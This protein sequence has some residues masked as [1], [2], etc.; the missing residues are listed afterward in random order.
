MIGMRRLG[1]AAGVLGLVAGLMGATS[2]A[3]GDIIYLSD[4]SWIKGKIVKETSDEYEV[5][6]KTSSGISYQGKLAKSRVRSITKGDDAPDAAK[7]GDAA[8]PAKDGKPADAPKAKEPAGDFLVVPLKGTFG[9][10]ITP[11]GVDTAL[12]WAV[13]KGVKHVVFTIDSPGGQVWAA[14]SIRAIIKDHAGKVTCHVVI[15]NAMSASIWVVFA[16]DKIGALPGA[17]LGAAVAFKRNDSGNAE[18]DEKFN[19]AIAAKIATE[20]DRLG[21]PGELARSMILTDQKLYAVQEGDA[22]KFVHD[23]P[24]GADVKF[25]TLNEGNRVVTLTTEQMLRYKVAS[26]VE[27]AE[28]AAIA[29][30]LGDAKLKP[31]GNMGESSMKNAASA[32]K[33]L[34]KAIDG[35]AEQVLASAALWKKALKDDDVNK[36]IEATDKYRSQLLRVG[37]LK[38][39]AK[40]LGMLEYPVFARINVAEDLKQVDDDLIKL[41]ELR[42]QRGGR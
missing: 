30:L 28:D 23:Q 2:W 3:L 14:E 37:A 1:R 19:S 42:R 8:A 39:S 10:E 16:C 4:G 20:A 18:V 12:D 13:A 15:Q 31:S 9:E 6:G 21:H 5:D 7:P 25:E 34:R 40:E 27:K 24:T 35:W 36:A 38:N 33:S 11:K 26:K 41:K 22:W 32:T 29:E 17:T